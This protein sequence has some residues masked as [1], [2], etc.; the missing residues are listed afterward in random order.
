VKALSFSIIRA[1][2]IVIKCKVRETVWVSSDG[3]EVVS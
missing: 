3:R 2:A 1:C